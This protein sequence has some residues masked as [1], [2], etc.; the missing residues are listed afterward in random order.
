MELQLEKIYRHFFAT[1]LIALM[2]RN[3]ATN[4]GFK[5][6]GLDHYIIKLSL[7][8]QAVGSAWTEQHA[9]LYSVNSSIY[10]SNQ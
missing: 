3:T 10:F 8:T 2:S 6:V 4:I 9:T 7:Q 1:T 5:Q